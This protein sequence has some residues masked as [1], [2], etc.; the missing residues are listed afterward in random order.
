MQ[1]YFDNSATSWPKPKSVANS[2]LEYLNDYGA[3]PGR[4][5]H[6]MALKSARMVF[7]TRELL[8]ELFNAETS[9][10]VIFTSNATNATNTALKG[11]LKK[12]DHVIIS[13][14]EH[15]ST[16]RPLRY[17]E[18]LGIIELS[19]IPCIKNGL[20]DIELLKASF[21]P[22]TKLVS[23][24]HGSNII[25]TIMPVAEIGKICR[26]KNVIFMVDAAQTAGHIPID[27]QKMNIDIL[28][29]S[30]HKSL[31]GPTGTGGL[32]IGK[33]VE[34]DALVH[35]GTGSKS[36]SE[37]HPDF[38]PDKL[39]AGTPNTFGIAGL[40]AG[41]KFIHS[42]GQVNIMQHSQQI[43]EYFINKLSKFDE[44]KVHGPSDGRNIL[45]IISITSD[46]LSPEIIAE[47]LDKE[48]N[49]MTRAGLMCCPLGHKA[50]GTYPNGTLRISLGYF[51]TQKEID[52][53]VQSL[54]KIFNNNKK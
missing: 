49:V 29:F 21:K 39:E 1:I 9:E 15:N 19:I 45:P 33:K 11:I 52:Y 50:L 46:L 14:M 38:Y 22:N 24:I 23:I 41:I 13:H 10:K 40:N 16:I 47:K 51:N 42:V 34:I 2:A 8:S 17:L 28:S 37:F 26:S 20:I 32:A 53:T 44:L 18:S 27:V 5:G 7:E 31:L 54:K 36:E 30:G 3:S 4:S 6:S 43:T 12:G 35:G 48:F 25:G